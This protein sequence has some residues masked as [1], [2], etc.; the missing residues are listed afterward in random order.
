DTDS[1]EDALSPARRHH[2]LGSH[3]GQATMLLS[4]P[5]SEASGNLRFS[6][7]L[8][9]DPLRPSRALLGS[10]S[11]FSDISRLSLSLSVAG[12]G[13]P[14]EKG[15]DADREVIYTETDT[16]TEAHDTEREGGKGEG[17]RPE[18]TLLA[19]YSS[20]VILPET[21]KIDWG[22]VTH[23]NGRDLYYR[24]PY[25]PPGSES[26][27][28]EALQK[29]EGRERERLPP[30]TLAMDTPG[31]K[32]PTRPKEYRDPLLPNRHSA[33]STSHS[34]DASSVFSH[35]QGRL[36]MQA[37]AVSGSSGRH[38][39]S[40]SLGPVVP[41]GT[42]SVW[43]ARVGCD[44]PINRMEGQGLGSLFEVLQGLSA[45]GNP[46][47]SG[48]SVFVT[49]MEV[50]NTLRRFKLRS[51][52]LAGSDLSLASIAECPTQSTQSIERG[53]TEDARDANCNP[54]PPSC[55]SAAP[56][57]TV[58]EFLSPDFDAHAWKRSHRRD[59]LAYLGY[60][61]HTH[62]S[63]EGVVSLNRFTAALMQF[64][65]MYS[66][67]GQPTYH[68]STHAVDVMQMVAVML[69][70]LRRTERGQTLAPPIVVGVMLLAA[71]AHDVEHVGVTSDLLTN[72]RHPLYH[73]FGSQAT[74]EQYHSM[75]GAYVLRYFSV[76]DDLPD[77]DRVTCETLFQ[78]LVLATD[79]RTVFASCD[80][81][82]ALSKGHAEN[83]PFLECQ[84]VL[85]SGI[86]RLADISNAARPFP[87]AKTHSLNVMSE[88]Y[89]T[90]DLEVAYGL[91]M[92]SFRD[93]GQ[94]PEGIRQCQVSFIDYVVRRYAASI[95]SF[96]MYAETDT[97]VS[98]AEGERE[99]DETYTSRPYIEGE[100]EV[101]REGESG[102][103]S[104]HSLSPAPSLSG[105]T[106]TPLATLLQSL[107]DTID[108]NRSL[109][110]TVDLADPAMLACL[111]TSEGDT[112]GE[113]EGE[114]EGEGD[115]HITHIAGERE[116]E[117]ERDTDAYHRHSGRERDS[118][119]EDP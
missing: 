119:R 24:A 99:V 92:G 79:P 45:E 10:P 81:M 9:G 3:S 23:E 26:V 86:M 104:T 66:D 80:A 27:R 96:A 6:S 72:I 90:G 106:D 91:E 71:A 17:T 32:T 78:G 60:L 65:R 20:S 73:L 12:S 35:G 47:V 95:A 83:T 2:T 50:L 16:C 40:G 88:F 30:N 84:E 105:D 67:S 7:Y 25:T 57:D 54:L 36:S 116:V 19:S 94:G 68:N 22:K 8:G 59:S 34:S 18:R 49:P 69:D 52:G 76:F 75:L 39:N 1:E 31:G 58:P 97:S 108:T 110:D 117:G 46:S 113:R 21:S 14:L 62:F 115:T 42:S 118:E 41:S 44:G 29:G 93:R 70:R 43:S 33:T 112:E 11:T 82:D 74:L 107:V 109:W 64:Q 28:G 103:S 38:S 98:V 114:G 111:N 56:S 15:Q 77:D 101:D 89:R 51:S 48:R 61:C 85:L 4:C 13:S 55:P 63:L 87:I 100:R 102:T 53:E 5:G 37:S